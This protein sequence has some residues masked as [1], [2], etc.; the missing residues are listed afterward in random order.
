MPGKFQ[1]ARHATEQFRTSTASAKQP[2]AAS[3]TASPALG[4]LKL[5]YDAISRFMTHLLKTFQS[6]TSPVQA[7]IPLA[8]VAPVYHIP[9]TRLH[10]ENTHPGVER[11]KSCAC[12]VS[13]LNTIGLIYATLLCCCG[14]SANPSGDLAYNSSFPVDGCL[15]TSIYLQLPSHS[16][17]L[18]HVNNFQHRADATLLEKWFRTSPSLTWIFST[19][20]HALPVVCGVYIAIW[21]TG[22]IIRVQEVKATVVSHLCWFPLKILFLL[23]PR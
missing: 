18:F 5:N 16:P 14:L 19:L 1:A 10:V 9:V 22:Q 7:P 17:R 23:H 6:A 11:S 13:N 20:A 2:L 15:A 21:A 12:R 4:D 3:P 8:R